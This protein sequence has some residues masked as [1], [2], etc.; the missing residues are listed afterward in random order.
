MRERFATATSAEGGTTS[1]SFALRVVDPT[2]SSIENS[3]SSGD[4]LG[5]GIGY[6]SAAVAQL[7]TGQQYATVG[8]SEAERVMG[9]FGWPCGLAFLAFRVLLAVTIAV[10]ALARARAL[11]PLAWLLAPL[12]VSSI[13]MC[14]LEQPTEQGFTVM[15][16]ALSLAALKPVPVP[17]LGPSV[18]ERIPRQRHRLEAK[19]TRAAVTRS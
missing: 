6:G 14:V 16:I 9:E 19:V 4:A 15:S 5:Q 17:K 1:G 12:T 2:V 3:V 11:D 7:L 18:P 10:K 8:E 13:L